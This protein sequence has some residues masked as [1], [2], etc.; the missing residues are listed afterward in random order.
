MHET[1]ESNSTPHTQGKASP[2]HSAVR[3]SLDTGR[4]EGRKESEVI[5]KRDYKRRGERER[6]M[7]LKK[8]TAT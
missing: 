1:S 8:K 7:R 6:K 3:G 4:E 2:E 5:W